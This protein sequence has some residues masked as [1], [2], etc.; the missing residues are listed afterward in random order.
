MD[1]LQVFELSDKGVNLTRMGGIKG[2]NEEKAR[3]HGRFPYFNHKI[4]LGEKFRR[5]RS[6]VK[7]NIKYY[8]YAGWR[9]LG[10]DF[11]LS[12]MLLLS[13]F[14]W[15]LLLPFFSLLFEFPIWVVLFSNVI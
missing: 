6:Y 3:G 13:R 11:F 5:E 1:R 12:W 2:L 7:T 14:R 15:I 4:E 9:Y 10:G 8:S